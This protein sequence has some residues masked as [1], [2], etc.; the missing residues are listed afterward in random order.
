VAATPSAL[1]KQAH[2]GGG[3]GSGWR[4]FELAHGAK[5]RRFATVTNASSHKGSDGD[6]QAFPWRG[7]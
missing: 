5:P 4:E 1:R 2:R 6:R 3:V 7:S